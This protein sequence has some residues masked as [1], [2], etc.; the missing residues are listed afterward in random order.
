MATKEIEKQKKQYSA[1]ADIYDDNGKIKVRL[2]MPGVSKDGLDVHVDND[3]LIIHGNKKYPEIPGHYQL[4]EIR[5]GDYHQEF[6]LDQTIDRNKIDAV[7]EK[8]ILTI[9]L[10][11][12]ESEKPKKIEVMNK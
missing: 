7:L 9:T 1:Y 8:G 6:T 2:E 10:E 12:K 3:T 4:R 11:T 5:N